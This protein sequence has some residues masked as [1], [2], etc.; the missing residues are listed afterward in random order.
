MELGETE[1]LGVF[2]DHDGRLRNVDADFDD[3]GRNENFRVPALKPLH[4]VVLLGARHLSVTSPTE[5]PNKVCKLSAR[6]SAA[7][8]SS[9]SLSSTSGQIQ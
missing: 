7:A 1:A 5:S 4:R 2:D 9:V 3:G 6:S 8:T